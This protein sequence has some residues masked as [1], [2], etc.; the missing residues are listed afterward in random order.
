MKFVRW[1]PQEVVAH[2]LDMSPEQVEA[3]SDKVR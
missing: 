1:D 3:E 2:I